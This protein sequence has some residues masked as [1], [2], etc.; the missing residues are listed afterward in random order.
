MNAAALA[1]ELD[2]LWSQYQA[3]IANPRSYMADKRTLENKIENL[4]EQL[5][6]L[7]AE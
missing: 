1:A 5:A 7:A 4:R 2:T 3:A 6:A